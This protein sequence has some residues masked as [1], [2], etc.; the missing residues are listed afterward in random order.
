M[1]NCAFGSRGLTR[2]KS[3]GMPDVCM[4]SRIYVTGGNHV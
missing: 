2:L 3:D 4:P 1:E